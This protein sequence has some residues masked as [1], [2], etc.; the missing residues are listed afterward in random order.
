LANDWVFALADTTGAPLT[1][2]VG[3]TNRTVSWY[4]PQECTAQFAID[5]RLPAAQ[6]V[7][8]R[9][10]DLLV[11]CDSILKYRGRITATQDDIDS[12]SH[13]IRVG[14]EDYRGM[15][16]DYRIV[17]AGGLTYT[18]IDQATIAWNLVTASQAMAGGNWGITRGIWAP[19]LNR[20]I[21]FAEGDQIGQDI[22]TMAVSAQGFD[23]EISPTLQLNVWPIPTVSVTEL[24]RGA[25]NGQYLVFGDNVVQA[26]RTM[27]PYANAI[28]ASGDGSQPSGY[29]DVVTNNLYGATFSPMGRWE[30]QISDVA[31]IST[32]N[33]NGM[34][35]GQLLQSASGIPSYLLT[36]RT[37]WWEPSALW[38]GDIVQVVVN[39]GRLA[40]NFQARVTQINLNLGDEAGEE[41]ISVYVGP[42][43]GNLLSSIKDQQSE[44]RRLGR[45]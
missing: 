3:A 29:A 26:R 20:T 13:T 33:L 42:I 22:N 5:A 17:P 36:L 7:I 1:D 10:T 45:R 18:S 37:G 32:T 2:L 16:N 39:S 40:E 38:L 35:L 14:A 43:V 21:T 11:Y 8:E 23:W 12:N 25:D 4:L 6:Y 41:M 15:L 24:G 31:I 34:A 44:I 28:R 27:V 9:E 30:R 19:S